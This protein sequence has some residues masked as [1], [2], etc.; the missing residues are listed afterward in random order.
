MPLGP[1]TVTV[2]AGRLIVGR[3]T[4]VLQT[5]VVAV[6]EPAVSLLL[7]LATGGGAFAIVREDEGGDLAG[8]RGVGRWGASRVICLGAGPHVVRAT[9]VSGGLVG[10][11]PDV[12]VGTDELAAAG[13]SGRRLA[14]R[15]AQEERNGDDGE[16]VTHCVPPFPMRVR[17][18]RT[19]G[20]G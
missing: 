18:H 8:R 5:V 17:R 19:L 16:E 20:N 1:R 2:L 10:V 3:S 4:E 14:G 13:G 15:G 9:R 7:E 12:G 6:A 11:G